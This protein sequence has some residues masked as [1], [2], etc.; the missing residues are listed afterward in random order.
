MPLHARRRPIAGGHSL[1]RANANQGEAASASEPGKAVVLSKRLPQDFVENTLMPHIESQLLES[2]QAY[3]PAELG[4]IARAYSKQDVRQYALCK[5]LADQVRDRISGFEAV[6]IVDI[7]APMW[8]LIPGDDDLFES[9]EQRTLVKLEDF[10]AL[11][12]IGIVRIF[13]KRATKHH[14]LLAQV[15][16]RLQKLL[17]EYEA[18]ELSEMLMSIAQSTEA[19]QDMDVLMILVPEIERRYSEVSLMHSIN[20]VWALTQL[21]VVHPGLLQR[22]A[23]DLGV[24]TKTKDLTPTY[25]ARIVWVYRRCDS[26][27]LV[28]E[29]MLPLIKASVAEF[30]C[31]E[32][33]RLAQALPEEG[34][35]LRTIA[36]TLRQGIEDMGRKDF[37]L[38][39]VGCVHGEILEDVPSEMQNPI[40]LVGQLLT[41]MRDEQDNFKRDEIQKIVYMLRF[42]PKYNHVVDALP[43]SWASTKEETLDFVRAQG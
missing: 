27:D 32:F 36:E 7:V 30:R 14:E 18:M 17:A 1:W 11:N 10:T 24:G 16:P 26:W 4:K 3:T 20:N 15:L 2:I 9:L 25:M 5:K 8:T 21:K 19:S 35:M 41:Y 34:A 37:L 40:S 38:F 33:A 31:R 22:V 28:S 39:L 43:A 13:N 42:A 29:S 6:D 23:Q 12:L